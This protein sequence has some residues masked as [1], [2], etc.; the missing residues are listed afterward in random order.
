MRCLK[1]ESHPEIKALE[2]V[3]GMS[4]HTFQDVHNKRIISGVDKGNWSVN[5]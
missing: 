1:F 3:L 2:C 5:S 4:R